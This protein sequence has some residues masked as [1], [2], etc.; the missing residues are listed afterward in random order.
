MILHPDKSG[1]SSETSRKGKRETTHYRHST[2][3]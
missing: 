1:Y 3:S 2:S